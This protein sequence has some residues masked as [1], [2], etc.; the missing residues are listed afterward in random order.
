[1]HVSTPTGVG[2]V[3]VATILSLQTQP[4]PNP[5]SYFLYQSPAFVHKLETLGS[6]FVVPCVRVGVVMRVCA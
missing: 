4:V 3:L 5:L 6:H 2:C 1:M